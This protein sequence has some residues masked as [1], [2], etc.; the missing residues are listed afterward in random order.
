MANKKKANETAINKAS[1]E[2]V[3]AGYGG[4]CDHYDYNNGWC[5]ENSCKRCSDDRCA[6]CWELYFQK[7]AELLDKE[8]LCKVLD[9]LDYCAI[10][11]CG[12]KDVYDE[13]LFKGARDQYGIVHRVVDNLVLPKNKQKSTMQAIQQYCEKE[14]NENWEPNPDIRDGWEV[15]QE[16]YNY[17]D[18]GQSYKDADFCSSGELACVKGFIKDRLDEWKGQQN[19]DS[20]E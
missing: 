16:I 10:V 18:D 5:K 20:F 1:R 14:N 12:K 15:V 6:E 17:I 13:Y 11:P 9:A 4:P 8:T 2:L 19:E 7:E 3:K